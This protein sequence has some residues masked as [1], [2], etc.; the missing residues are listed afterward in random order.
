[1]LRSSSV[2]GLAT[3][4]ALVWFLPA[5]SW[6]QQVADDDVYVVQPGDTCGSVA[7]K[8]FGD[9][10][11]GSA[12]LH[13][14]NKMGPP[15]HELKPGTVL[16]I[17]GDPDARLTFVKPEVNAKRA[18]KVEWRQANTGQGLWRLDSVNTLREAGAEVT[19]KDLTR[20]QMNENAL[21]VIYGQAPKA[22]DAVMK[23]GAVELLQGELNVSLAELRGEPVGVQMPAASVA[24]RSKELLVGV[25]AQQT[26]RVSVYDGQAEVRAQGQ[27]VQVPRDHGT[28][29]EKGK[30]P[31]KPRPLPKAPAWAGPARPVR[32]LLDEK[33]VDEE[34]AW[35]PVKEAASY[36]VE[37]A[38]DERFNDRVHG[39]TVPA[40]QE[41]L[42]S[43][44]RALAP[45][46][47]FARVRAVD[48]SGLV[49]RVSAVRQVEVLRVKSERGVVGPQGLR[50]AMRLDV[51]VDGAESL[52]FRLD[53]AP[54]THPVRVEAVGTHTLE[55]LPRGVPDAL[56]EKLT[57]TVVPPRVDVDLEPMASSFRVKVQ[58]FDEQG[59]LLEGPFAALKLR[60]LHGT[61]VEEPLRRQSDGALLTRAVPG[62]RDGE[63][64]A[65]VEAL[66]GDT[67]VQQ[68]NAQANAQAPL[69]REPAV[70]GVEEEP[71]PLEASVE[72]EAALMS[73]LGAPSG[74]MVE[75]APLPTGFLP[76]AWLFELRAQPELES[77][78][79]DLA[80]GRTTLAVEGRVSER[81]ALGTALAM[82]PGALLSGD[83]VAGEL[84]ATALSASLSARVRLTDHPAFRVL[85]SFDGTLVGSGFDEEA[86]GLRLRPALL[87]GS[88]WGQWAF[89]TSQGYAL[90]PG[91]AR[92]SWDSA[93]QAWFLPIPRLALGAEIDA[94]VDATPREPGPFAFAA[95]VGARLMFSGFELGTSVRRGFGP[96]GARVWGGWSGQV[97]LGWSGLR[98]ARR[99]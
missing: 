88:R 58:V 80:R 97:T 42:K 72:E 35:A 5:P 96:D 54:T 28:R 59:R 49:G 82:R 8:V 2:R 32:V 66:W 91:E 75:A 68:V 70:S 67:R 41:S 56:P 86:R 93:Y 64:V 25:D 73:M 45:G 15:P 30:V 31:E 63:R 24:A 77:A 38:R 48:A 84:P 53:G 3:V 47:Y 40:G 87:A 90:R 14:L 89:S 18:G 4:L 65:S 23:S 21:V 74:G 37:L 95:G 46:R 44:A 92:A 99:Q 34:L 76:R 98:P 85:L 52:D 55:L 50:G 36:R 33:G 29:V 71:E 62:M 51:S 6:A 20:L 94:L 60:G 69:S 11:V 12:K 13:A 22:T 19:F 83:G 39:E 61:Q 78:G 57:L 1:M 26:S 81:V 27:S 10:T 17:K 9:V 16:R 7:R 79:V 43:V